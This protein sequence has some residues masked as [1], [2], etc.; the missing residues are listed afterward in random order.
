M[1]HSVCLNN[2]PPW[3]S[4]VL[5]ASGVVTA[6]AVNHHMGAVQ[7]GPASFGVIWKLVQIQNLGPQTGTAVSESSF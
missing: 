3:L 4:G 7:T 6:V 2:Q 1:L 5:G